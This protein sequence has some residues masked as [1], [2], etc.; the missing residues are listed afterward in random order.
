MKKVWIGMLSSALLITAW[1]VMGMGMGVESSGQVEGSNRDKKAWVGSWTASPQFP[2]GEA[3]EGVSNRTVRMILRPH[4]EGDRVRVRLSNV[5]GEGPV[6]FGAASIAVVWKDAAT[7]PGSQRVLTFNGKRSVTLEAGQ[8]V[9]S[10]PV[11][12]AVSRE[13][14]VA[15]NVFVEGDS[16]SITWHRMAKQTSFLSEKGNF[17]QDHHP[18]PFIKRTGSWYWVTGLDVLAPEGTGGIVCLGDSITDGAG[19]TSG[20]NARYPDFLSDRLYA[21]GISHGV[22]NAGISGNKILRDDPIYGPRA[23]DR[24]QRDVLDQPGVTHVIVLEGINDIGHA[25]G[26]RDPAAIISGLRQLITQA[27]DRGLKIVGGTLPPFGGADYYTEEGNTV[28]RQVNEWIR[29]SGEFDGV[30]DFDAALRD[31][32]QPHRL[33][34]EYDSGDHL[35]PSDAGYRRMAEE[36]DLTL[37]Q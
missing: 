10:D 20:A 1:T 37:F 26:E 35:H 23:L 21:E 7:V 8:S 34:P 17:T 18:H 9:Q 14:D 33:L 28:R 25:P 11:R 16:G 2:S 3:A 29:N 15:V 32:Q 5:F 19:S 13:R 12:F 27:H 6:T 31:P 24:F 22:M 30:I 36:V 4:L